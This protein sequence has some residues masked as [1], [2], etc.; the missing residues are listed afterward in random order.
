[1]HSIQLAQNRVQWRVLTN[2]AMKLRVPK[3]AGDL[4]SWVTASFSSTVLWN[5][6]VLLQR[7]SASIVPNIFDTSVRLQRLDS[8]G[9]NKEIWQRSL[10]QTI[11]EYFYASI[12]IEES[13]WLSRHS[14][15]LQAGRPG[16]NSRQGHFSL[17]HSVQTGTG[18]QATSYPTV[19]VGNFPEPEAD[20]SPPSIVEVNNGFVAS[21]PHH[22]FLW[23]S[24]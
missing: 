22:M 4:T 14:D 2:T 16:F 12:T 3:K 7:V 9:K 20:H 1:M 15:R 21:Q 10:H 23:Y 5:Y 17:L 13:G 18:A 6:L 24:A 8:K 19:A 11:A